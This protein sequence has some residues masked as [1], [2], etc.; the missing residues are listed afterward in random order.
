MKAALWATWAALGCTDIPSNGT[1]EP[2][3][4]RWQ[5]AS[6]EPLHNGLLFGHSTEYLPPKMGLCLQR[7]IIPGLIYPGKTLALL[8]P[9]SLRTGHRSRAENATLGCRLAVPLPQGCGSLQKT[10]CACE[11]K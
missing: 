9:G 4:G 2:Y 1:L 10:F 5:H 3:P 6:N 11:D 8:S 7:Q